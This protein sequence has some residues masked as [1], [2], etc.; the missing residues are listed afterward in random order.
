MA[1]EDHLLRDNIIIREEKMYGVPIDTWNS[2]S[3][4]KQSLWMQDFNRTPQQWE[5]QYGGNMSAT[6]K[7]AYTYTTVVDTYTGLDSAD[8]GEKTN[9]FIDD[10]KET[11][12][13]T[14]QEVLATG[15]DLTLLAGLVGLA[16]LFKK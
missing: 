9:E 10:A 14:G 2:W 4:H 6:E 11:V 16:L 8:L 5:H 3:T 12:Y 1:Y 13:T 7:A 15:R